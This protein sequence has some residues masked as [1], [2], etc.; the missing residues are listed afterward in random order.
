MSDRMT[1]VPFGELMRWVLWEL[2]NHGTLFELH[3]RFVPVPGKT[4]ELFGERLETP[5]GPAAGPATQL[6]QNLLAAYYA[7][8]RFF[9]LKTVQTLDGEDLPVSKPCIL[10][11][12]EGYN[13]E[14]STELRVQEAFDE[15]VKA[16]FA[17]KLLTREHGWGSPDGFVFNMSVG[18]NF[19][20]ITSPKIDDFIEGLKDASST[21][22]WKEC[23]AWAKAHLDRFQNVDEA[24][25]DGIS[26]RVCRSITL[27]TLHGC[28]PQEIERIASYLIETK[29]LHTFV[30]CNPTLLGYDFARRTMDEMGYD[31][32]VFDDHHFR[33]DLQ[34]HDAVPMFRRLQALAGQHGLS[35]GLKL[36]NTFPVKIARGELPGNEMYMSGRPLYPL[37]MELARRISEEFDGQ[38]RLSFS[39]GADAFNLEGL[40]Q[41]GIW[42][43]TMATT[44][45]KPG[46]Y[47]RFTQMGEELSRHEYR[48]FQGVSVGQVDHLARS[49][50]TDLHHLQ[51]IKPPPRYKL[52]EKVP[53]FS[54]FTAPCTGG[55]PI[56][57]DIP[58]Y[59][60]LVGQGRHL[61]ALRLI[62][63]KNAL[64]F[65]TGTICSHPCMN[66]CVRNFYESSVS[67]RSSKLTA[68][69]NGFLGLMEELET[70]ART[71]DQRVA[72]V[73]GGPA[74]MAAAFFL[75]RAGVPVTLF[76]KREKL[77]GI[78]RYVVP[79]FRMP[80]AS[81]DCDVAL[82]ERMGV[83]VR[84]GTEAPSVRE[85]QA[86]GYAHV[87]VALGA[88]APGE[89]RLEKGRAM[90]SL[91][92]L[93][94]RR[95]GEL[96]NL[97]TDVVI[98]GGGNTAMDVARVAKRTRGVQHARLVYR[99]TRR[100]MPADLEELQMALD[101][102]V[103][104]MELL[105][106]VSYSD[107]QLTCRKM[108]LGPLDASGR[109]SPVETDQTVVVPCTTLVAAVGE[110]VETRFFQENGI[111]LTERGKVKVNP[112]T[113]ETSI[114]GVYVLG[115]ANRG[116][117]TVVEAIADARKVADALAGPHTHPLPKVSDDLYARH[118]ILKLYDDAP[119]E[120]DRCLACNTVC[121]ACV[122][123]CPNRAY[124][125]MKVPGLPMR[126][127]LHLDRGCNDC[128]NCT[129]FC[130][131]DSDPY[132][133]KLTLFVTEHEFAESSTPG[134]LHLGE[135]R[136][137]VRL[138]ETSEV[139]LDAPAPGLDPSLEKV[140][141]TLLEDYRY[142][143]PA[144]KA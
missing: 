104:I 94:L 144:P 78:V 66:K 132:R 75:G 11:A 96:S 77:G 39:G 72:I 97:G 93:E 131:Y 122:Q 129:A 32:L 119:K 51:S 62:V 84:T 80:D 12:Q 113:L 103:E 30:K 9:E 61:E 71:T 85:L 86:Q 25:V 50:R 110:K 29:K 35:F 130:P 105:A 76:E 36:T 95:K 59:V 128:G 120:R 16:W 116:P 125:S 106:P 60:N 65:I 63:E 111:A 18:Y 139:D 67:I 112:E 43:I 83:E 79:G 49:A 142:L 2:K 69:A 27:S 22:I 108:V 23:V 31:E 6:S 109:R 124:V 57:Q 42:P 92:F 44:L 88:W 102:G 15:Y 118:G 17:L 1:P 90:N 45:L 8:S 28:P 73:G 41:A 34:F 117:A 121:E 21:P 101:D 54:C 53:L 134:F 114:P 115:D 3:R 37:T 26:P 68:A 4:L 81:I 40:F 123:V 52:D 47:Q 89:V 24:Y 135:K 99:R 38:M 46:G 13:V 91:E 48:P 136:F 10:A 20:G 143:L 140:L 87:L 5:F 74:G 133:E 126:Q 138:E 58:E 64:P 137:R 19:E 107:G 141:G 70:P 100:Y 14:W 7:G 56:H 82:M 127:I 98:L 33:H 55:C